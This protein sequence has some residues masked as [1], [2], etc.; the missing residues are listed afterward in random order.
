MDRATNDSVIADSAAPAGAQRSPRQPLGGGERAVSVAAGG[1]LA[2]WG[3]RRGGALGWAAGLAGGLLVARGL[4]GMAP[5]RRAFAP[6]RLEEEEARKRGWSSAAAASWSVTINRPRQ[7]LYDFWRNF[8]NLAEI[9]EY[10]EKVEVTDETRSEWSV[11]G[12]AGV[13][14]KWTALVTEDV[15]GQ[16]IAWSSEEKAMVKN[17]GWVEFRD[18]PAGQGTEVH[19]VILYKPPAGQTGRML[20]KL[21]HREPTIQLR[22]DLR[23]FKQ[24]ME[25][26]EITVNMPQSLVNG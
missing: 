24:L 25:A 22:R 13:T 19:A 20:A 2:G 16:R 1:L 4:A 14:L 17:T 10:V 8:A 18:A 5:V 26:G 21:L 6:S 23:R 12:P 15:P 7:E 9:M 11:K 3:I